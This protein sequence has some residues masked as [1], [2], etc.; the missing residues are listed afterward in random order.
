MIFVPMPSVLGYG[1]ELS[2]PLESYRIGGSNDTLHSHYAKW[3]QNCASAPHVCFA[4]ITFWKAEDPNQV[5]TLISAPDESRG[6][7]YIDLLTQY[8]AD[9]H[10]VAPHFVFRNGLPSFGRVSNPQEVIQPED[11]DSLVECYKDPTLTHKEEQILFW[12]G[13]NREPSNTKTPYPPATFCVNSFPTSSSYTQMGGPSFFEDVSK[14]PISEQWIAFINALRPLSGDLT[15]AM[16]D[17]L[18]LVVGAPI[19]YRRSVRSN[20][21]VQIASV[22]FG[23]G[24]SAGE[25]DAYELLRWITLHLYVENMTFLAHRE[26]EQQQQ[27]REY[28]SAQH[29]ITRIV[30]IIRASSPPVVLE[31]IRTYFNTLYGISGSKLVGGREQGSFPVG[32]LS[33]RTLRDFIRSALDEAARIECLVR[34]SRVPMQGESDAKAQLDDFA[35]C[36]LKAATHSAACD[37]DKV[38]IPRSLGDDENEKLWFFSNALTAVFRNVIQHGFDD[39]RKLQQQIDI[40]VVTRGGAALLQ[41]DN[42]EVNPGGNIADRVARLKWSHEPKTLRTVKHYVRR[43][44]GEENQVRIEPLES[45]NVRLWRTTIPLPTLLEVT[46]L[47]SPMEN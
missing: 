7:L 41:I 18:A 17:P 1:S 6:K 42:H 44:G 15:N 28:E 21:Y 45:G 34:M 47:S 2:V 16:G 30:N 13:P 22:F 36:V 9:G 14:R 25:A 35:G 39:R 23:L 32:F 46:P 20:E 24:A 31:T 19:G 10:T 4:D 26:G 11:E 3:L 8:I 29:E 12:R 38:L 33:A 40:C 37:A 43:F 5:I 27:A